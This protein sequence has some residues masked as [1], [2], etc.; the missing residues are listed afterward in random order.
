MGT[1]NVH[2]QRSAV[3]IREFHPKDFPA[4]VGIWNSLFPDNPTTVEHEQFEWEAFDTKRF[5]RR[6][7]VALDAS[8]AIVGEASFSHIMSAYHPQRFGMWIGVHP[9]W[10]QRE[11]GTALYEHTVRSVLGFEAVA[12]RT[13]TRET[14]SGTVAWL[15]RRGFKE[16]MR[17]WE[18]HL[19]LAS[20]DPAAFQDRWVLP[21]GISVATLTEELGRDP[22]AIRTLYDLD[23]DISPDEPRIDPFTPPPFEFYRDW[24]L[25]RPGAVPDAVFIA[26]DGDL[27]VGLSELFRNDALPG[28][29]NTGFTGVRRAYRGRG[30]AFALK[31]RALE[32]AKRQRYGEVR[33]WNSTLNAPILGINVK[34]GFARHPAWITFGKELSEAEAST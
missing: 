12:L 17:G 26:K 30:I 4:A 33:T 3:T 8:D 24:V 10:Q 2:R 6:R 9:Q 11:V 7:Y 27:Y 13:W 14:M 15:E 29:L 19:D 1:S 21:T 28:V 16:L 32:W 23:V 18:S 20:F 22:E 34:L 5:V 31:V 25:K